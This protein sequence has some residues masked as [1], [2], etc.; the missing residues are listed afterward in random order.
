MTFEPALVAGTGPRGDR[1][2]RRL[3]AVAVHADRA[4]RRAGAATASLR[5]IRGAG[6]GLGRAGE[7]RR[8]PAGQPRR[9]AAR[10]RPAGV[11]PPRHAHRGRR[12]HPSPSAPERARG[13]RRRSPAAA[14]GARHVRSSPPAELR[15]RPGH[16]EPDGRDLAR[17]VAHRV[18]AAARLDRRRA[19]TSVFN[20]GSPRRCANGS[21]PTA[22]TRTSSEAA[23]SSRCTAGPPRR[24][25]SCPAP[26]R[27][28]SMP[29]SPNAIVR[30]RRSCVRENRAIVAERRQRRRGRQL[31]VVGLVAV[32]VAVLGVFGAVQWRSAVDA[33]R[34]VDDLLDGR[35]VSSR[36]R[37]A[38]AD[39]DPEL[40]LLLAMQSVRQTVDL[41]LRHRGGGRRSALRAPGARGPVRRRS[42]APG[43]GQTGTERSRRRVC[44]AAERV[45]R[46]A[47]SAWTGA[48]PT[49]NAERSSP[50]RARESR[51]P[52]DLELQGGLDAYG[53]RPALALAGT[54]VTIVSPEP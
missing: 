8:G 46:L 10:G 51:R 23:C 41:G 18:D 29:A 30:R 49:A 28:S 1:S 37:R 4:V 11:P 14:L 2:T 9:R 15:S 32:L 40:A 13:S 39:K 22:P 5:H 16:A 50:T 24:R 6:R 53:A 33:K 44:P 19:T 31:V 42:R 45:D 52:E 36:P 48:S 26:N 47:E 25:C 38:H 3:A 7:A 35:S 43:R 17:G 20:G 34:D 12:G 27:R 21:P 54:T